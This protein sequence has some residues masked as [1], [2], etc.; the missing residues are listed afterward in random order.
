MK[1][2]IKYLPIA[3]LFLGC[4]NS[5]VSRTEYDEVLS[6]VQ[7]LEAKNDSLRSELSFFKD[8]VECLEEDNDE[9]T[10]ELRRTPCD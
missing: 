10:E 8:Y 1:R 2:Y 9:L 5:V 7:E 3:I 6:Y 4:D